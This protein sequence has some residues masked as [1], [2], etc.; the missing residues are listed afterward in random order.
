[1][2]NATSTIALIPSTEFKWTAQIQ[3][4]ESLPS[5]DAAIRYAGLHGCNLIVK[6]DRRSGPLFDVMHDP[7]L[8]Y[9]SGTAVN[10]VETVRVEIEPERLGWRKSMARGVFGLFARRLASAASVS[11]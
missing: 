8:A 1:M 3:Y 5:R 10:P 2:T 7:N 6:Y 4:K 9:E 11:H